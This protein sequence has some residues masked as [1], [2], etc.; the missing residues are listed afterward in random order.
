[1]S[2]A[3][4]RAG[5][6]IVL[7][8]AALAA[9]GTAFFLM[10]T[11]TA[12]YGPL[13]EHLARRYQVSLSVAGA[14]L[15]AQY[16]GAVVGVVAS[17]WALERLPGR[18]PVGAAFVFLG[19]GCGGV[20]LA[21]SWNGLLAGVFVIGLGYGSLDIGLN[22]LVAHSQGSRRSALLNGLNGAYGVGA[23]A[24]P[25]L[26]STFGSQHL[27]LLYSVAALLALGLVPAVIGIS[28]RLPV[29]RSSVSGAAGRSGLLVVLFVIAFALY[30]GTEA[31]VGGWMTSH[32]EWVGL[33]TVAAAALTSG[34]WGA[35]AAGRLLVAV[36]PPSVP[37]A[38]VVLGGSAVAA[39]GLLAALFG[40][41]APVTYLVTGLGLAPIFPTGIVWLARLRPGDS[42]ATSW[43]FPAS[44]AGG[45]LVP[46]GVGIVIAHL[47]LGWVPAVLSAVAFGCLGAFALAARLRSRVPL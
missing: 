31:G 35:L 13:L 16:A 42:R 34:F 39:V 29:A 26:I 32:L 41:A 25:F 38:A 2:R 40:G 36:V 5:D 24:G 27:A 17:M 30:V 20:A 7:S 19:L 10:G 3:L 11:L 37:E 45:A 33:G 46:G 8:S 22:Q 21:P 6:R 43:L 23:V 28:G 15:S 18:L 14:V 12:A 44:M 9:V 4:T 1:M 47:S